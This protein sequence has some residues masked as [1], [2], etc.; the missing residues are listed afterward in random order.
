MTVDEA[1][2]TIDRLQP[3]RSYLTHL[4]HELPWDETSRSLPPGISLAYDG[5][6]LDF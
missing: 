3:R 6:S 5:L 4:S 2:D 1:L